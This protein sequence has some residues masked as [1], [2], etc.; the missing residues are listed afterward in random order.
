MSAL[1]R[2]F[3]SRN[4][5]VHGY[6]KTPSP[7][8]QKLSEEGMTIHY[9]DNPNKIP[10]NIDMVIYTPAIPNSLLEF[11]AIK[12]RKTPLFKR[13]EI[14]GMISKEHFT[15]AIAGTHGKTSVTSLVAHLLNHAGKNVSAFIGGIAKNFNSNCIISKNTEIV[16]VEADEYDR[17]FLKI[18]PDIAVITSMDADHLDIYD[19][20]NALEDTFNEFLDNIRPNGTAIVLDQLPAVTKSNINFLEYG[21]NTKTAFSVTTKGYHNGIHILDYLLQEELLKEVSFPLPGRYNALNSLVASAIAKLLHIPN[22]KII[23]GL[24]TFKGVERRFDY[25]YKHATITY[26]DDYAHHPNEIKSCIEAVKNLYP[27]KTITGIFQP[28]LFTRTRDFADEFATSLS[29]LDEVILL[30]IYP[31]REEA[32]PGITS[33]FLLDK[34]SI[35]KK[36][37]LEKDE[38]IKKVSTL[39]TDILLTLGAGD[40]DRLI[41]P[42]EQL[43]KTKYND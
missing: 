43:L 42:I 15:I 20:K 9:K 6:D 13:A 7:L 26:I 18:S 31:A 14:L 28:H 32:I 39:K 21:Y 41:K 29:M 36:S 40:I 23:S 8:T 34:I 10:D 3:N 38:I 37:L 33:K 2:Y 27:N 5:D 11:Q 30:P 24:K 19:N 25:R 16:V 22:E 35:K 12:N 17:S 4:I 1:A